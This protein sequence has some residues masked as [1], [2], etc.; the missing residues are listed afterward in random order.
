[1]TSIIR[2]HSEGTC[3]P[4]A[5][6]FGHW[7]MNVAL[8]MENDRSLNGGR[9]CEDVT[10]PRQKKHVCN[11]SMPGY[12]YALVTVVTASTDQARL[13]VQKGVESEQP[14]GRTLRLCGNLLQCMYI[15]RF[16]RVCPCAGISRARG[17]M[18]HWVVWFNALLYRARAMEFAHVVLPT[19]KPDDVF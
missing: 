2:N 11:M 15:C 1:M 4:S 7:S 10:Q 9:R 13:S 16:G 12:G 6:N 17:R 8:G 19:S 3:S 18:K 5:D 14:L